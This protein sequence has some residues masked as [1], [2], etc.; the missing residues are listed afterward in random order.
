MILL[1]TQHELI[2]PLSFQDTTPEI[3]A[4]QIVPSRT[5]LLVDKTIDE[6]QFGLYFSLLLFKLFQ[7]WLFLLWHFNIWRRGFFSNAN[8]FFNKLLVL[9]PYSLTAI[10]LNHFRVSIVDFLCGLSI[11]T[12][13]LFTCL[14]LFIVSWRFKTGLVP[15]FGIGS[16]YLILIKFHLLHLGC[17]SVVWHKTCGS[18]HSRY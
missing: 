11:S 3:L 18:C 8:T 1:K 15:L 9:F 7:F 10:K 5:R 2:R 4:L 14:N 17:F 12:H 16:W 6:L 13:S